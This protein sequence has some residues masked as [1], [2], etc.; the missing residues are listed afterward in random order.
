MKLHEIEW[1]GAAAIE[2]GQKQ[3]E[4]G[5]L[6]RNI[7]E[8]TKSTIYLCQ[9]Q[10][11]IYCFHKVQRNNTSDTTPQSV[12][13]L[14]RIKHVLISYCTKLVDIRSTLINSFDIACQVDN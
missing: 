2:N 14:M 8:V 4:D 11:G 12:L 10:T 9:N 1:R 13:P 7:D 6:A 5:L 3:V